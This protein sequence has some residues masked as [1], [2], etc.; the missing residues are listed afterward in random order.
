VHELRIRW[1]NMQTLRQ[2]QVSERA[3]NRDG[4]RPRLDVLRATFKEMQVSIM[5]RG[6]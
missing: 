6:A 3:D 4:T 1:W 5:A 2:R